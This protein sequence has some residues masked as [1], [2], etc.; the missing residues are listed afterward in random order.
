MYLLYVVL[1]SYSIGNQYQSRPFF[2]SAPTLTLIP[3]AMTATIV[4]VKIANYTNYHDALQDMLNQGV[5][6]VGW[7]NA[8]IYIPEH[9]KFEQVF[10]NRSGSSCLYVD[11]LHRIAYSVDMGD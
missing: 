1:L 6:H 8:G 7:M 9:L 5:R 3:L 10:S 4:P 2:P 11:P